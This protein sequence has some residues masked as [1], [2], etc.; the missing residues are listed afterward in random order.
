MS[1]IEQQIEALEFERQGYVTFGKDERVAAVDDQLAYWRKQLKKRGGDAPTE[2]LS[3][4]QKKQAEGE[5]G[6][7]SE[8]EAAKTPPADGEKIS[9][10]LAAAHAGEAF[11]GP[12][13][14]VTTEPE[15]IADPPPTGEEQA[16][17]LAAQQAAQPL[18]DS[19]EPDVV[20]E[21]Q[22]V[23]GLIRPARNASSEE[24]RQYAQSLPAP[25]DVAENAGRD[26]IVAAYIHQFAPSGNASKE[27]WVKY[28]NDHGIDTDD[29]SRDEI[30]AAAVDAGW[31]KADEP[32]QDPSPKPNRNTAD[33]TPRTTR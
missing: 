33:K 19:A 32:P 17:E 3:P 4:T 13:T 11:T 8:A 10:E 9:N 30:R 16:N 24:W 14:A 26:E 28:A 5:G 21:A 12:D 27:T 23:G 29:K 2:P 25:L 15:L 20:T 22:V 6:V 31:A 1:T 18:P 7:I